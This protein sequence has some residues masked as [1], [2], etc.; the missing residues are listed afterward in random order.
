MHD[1]RRLRAFHAVAQTGSFSAAGLELG[2]AQSV[3]S[4]HVAALEREFGVTLVNR[5]TRPVSITDAGARLLRHAEAVLGHVTAAEDELRAI[6]GLQGGTLRVGAFLSA[7][8]SFLPPALA[9]FEQEH[10]DVTVSFEQL[11]EPEALR[12]IR[13]GALD[14]AVVWRIPGFP[15]AGGET[16]DEGIDE[17]HLID[18]PY[19]VVL[20]TKHRL[21]RRR[22]VRLT[23]LADERFTAPSAAGHALPYREMLDRLCADAG[24]EPRIHQAEDVTVARAI[25]AAG[26]GVGLLS[27]L[28]MPE[29]RPDI[30]LRPPRDINPY[31]S[32]HATW[33]RGRR[34]P[35]V[36]R[37]VRYLTEA[38]KARLGGGG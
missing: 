14:L 11:E 21:A 25:V 37:M 19:L 36:S 13:S 10:P 16:V 2:Y 22:Q 17:L 30:A 18:D 28:T 26:L 7:C 9:R 15:A 29:P 4:H 8:N 5:G 1:L 33:L 23:D 31:R 34:V 6:A 12:R 3:V 24:F 35:A 32:V 27:E 38:A 20:P